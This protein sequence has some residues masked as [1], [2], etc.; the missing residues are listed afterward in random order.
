MEVLYEE[1]SPV[2]EAAQGVFSRAFSEREERARGKRV[3]PSVR[4]TE[5]YGFLRREL[6][7]AKRDGFRTQTFSTRFLG[8]QVRAMPKFQGVSTR[9][10][11][12]TIQALVE[13]GFLQPLPSKPGRSH[14]STYTFA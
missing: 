1:Q 8:A 14:S 4:E 10:M 11:A 3:K 13:E 7:R 6:M 2:S 9:E 5:L 12:A